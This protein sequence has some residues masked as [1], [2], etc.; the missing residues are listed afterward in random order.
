MENEKRGEVRPEVDSDIGI[1]IERLPIDSNHP[2]KYDWL[3]LTFLNL[4]IQ[5]AFI[6]NTRILSTLLIAN[7]GLGKTIKLD[8]LRQFDF[9]KYSLDVTPK[10]IAG[11]LDDVDSGKCKFLVIPDYIATLGHS[12]KTTE[13]ARSIFR[14]M[15]EEGIINVDIFGMERHYRQ[16]VKAGLISGITPEYF[17]ENSRIWKSDG[18]LQRFLPFSYSHTNDTTQ[19]VLTNM[20]DRVDTIGSF[21]M[22]VKTKNIE[23]PVRTEEID[24]K[25]KILT[26]TLLEPKE[27]PYRMYQQCVALC[28]ANAVLRDSRQVEKEDVELVT[29]LSTY[30]NRSQHPI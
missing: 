24:D 4:V 18:F 9:V 29:L 16:K 3:P 13:L 8:F 27:P 21:K 30:I 15:I 10:H 7:A 28:N 22:S 25:I 20:R 19:R 17:A 12:K 1:H 26:Y 5:T 23:E 6:P 2:T 11:F 14:G